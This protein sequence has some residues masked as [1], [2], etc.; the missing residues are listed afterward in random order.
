MLPRG[1]KDQI[2]ELFAGWPPSEQACPFSLT[3]AREILELIMR[4]AVP[5]LVSASR[6]RLA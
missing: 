4:W 5:I 1:F 2:Y 3:L 6:S